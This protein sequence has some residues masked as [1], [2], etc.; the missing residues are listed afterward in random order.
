MARGA[1]SVQLCQRKRLRYFFDACVSVFDALRIRKR[2]NAFGVNQPLLETNKIVVGQS[3]IVVVHITPRFLSGWNR[4]LVSSKPTYTILQQSK[5]KV[6]NIE[7]V[8]KGLI[9]PIEKPFVK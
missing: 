8:A 9:Y 5:M 3:G 6:V 7:V 2:Q 1:A 4:A